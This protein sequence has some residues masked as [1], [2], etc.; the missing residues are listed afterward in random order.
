MDPILRVVIFLGLLVPGYGAAPA[1]AQVATAPV[2]APAHELA[3]LERYI[4]DAMDEWEVPGLAIAVIRNDSVIFA[5]GYGERVLGSGEPVDE[6]T[7]FA[8]ASTTKAMTVGALGMLVDEGELDWDDRVARH[9]P[10][11]EF[12]DPYVE[13]HV[14]IRDLLT[15]RTG[16]SRDDNVWIAAPFDRGEVLR[17]VRH[18]PQSSGFRRGYGYNNIMYMVAGEIVAAASGLEWDDFIE[19]RIFDPL[20]MDRSTTRTAVVEGRS[21]VAIG[22]TRHQGEILPMPRRN[23]DALGPAG[24]VWSSAEDMARWIRLQLGDGTFEG[25]QLL[26]SE[27]IEEMREPQEFIGT[28]TAT[29]RLFPSRNFRAYGMGWRLEDY[30]GRKVVQHTG[31]VNYTSTQVGLIPSEAIGVVVLVNYSGSRLHTALMYRVFDLLLGLPATDWSAELKVLSDRS[32]AAAGRRSEALEASRIEGTR[33]SLALDAYAGTYSDDLYGDVEVALEGG[34]LVLRYSPD[35][36]ADLEHWHH[37]TFRAVWRTTG[38]GAPFATFTLDPR[39]RA[40]ALDLQG[41]ATFRR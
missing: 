39:G 36:I 17:R 8:I 9:L 32:A 31:G 30:H 6:S 13:R 26:E 40:A 7:L 5:E 10:A 16:V 41:F 33:P 27:T 1:A 14:T 11:L 38:F 4:R 29:Q 20:G 37:D 22:H 24:S 2:A 19:T 34:G 35:Y 25:R 12:A 28:D 15:H 3:G 23:Y 21:N 18:L